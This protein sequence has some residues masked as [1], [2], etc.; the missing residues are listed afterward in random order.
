M[1]RQ[2]NIKS[3]RQLLNELNEVSFAVDDL[4]LFLDTHPG[5]EEALSCYREASGKR[6][7][8]LAEYADCYGPLT[9]DTADIDGAGT[10]QWSSQPFPW[11]REGGCR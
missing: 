2:E 11:E 9:A 4:L 10:W 3:R 7:A 8:L 5:D 1:M 6:N